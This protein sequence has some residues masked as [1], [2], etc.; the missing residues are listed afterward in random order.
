MISITLDAIRAQLVARPR[1]L[2]DGGN[3]S[4]R[5][6]GPQSVTASA[7]GNTADGA[8]QRAAQ[9]WV[10]YA[11]NLFHRRSAIQASTAALGQL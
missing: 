7:P 11:L 4:R 5:D 6:A 9:R 8:A 10:A 1:V 2:H 3:A